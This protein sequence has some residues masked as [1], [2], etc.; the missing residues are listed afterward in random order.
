MKRKKDTY[1]LTDFPMPDSAAIERHLILDVCMNTTTMPDVA[2]LVDRDM[3]TDNRQKIWDVIADL[4]ERGIEPNMF[5]VSSQCLKEFAAEITAQDMIAGGPVE[6][7]SFASKLRTANAKMRTYLAAL[8]ML[9]I[10]QDGSLDEAEVYGAVRDASDEAIGTADGASEKTLSQVLEQ[11]RSDVEETRELAAQGKKAIVTT[12]IGDL[13]YELLG[14]FAPTQL[15]IIAARPSVG[16]TALML[17][18]AKD[19]AAGGA[20]SIIF[21]IEMADTE[22]GQ[23]LMCA[24]GQVDR[25][26]L[27]D[28]SVPDA[29]L[30]EAIKTYDGLPLYI[31]DTACSLNEIVSR[32]TSA[33]NRLGIKAAFIDYL[34]LI[35]PGTNDESVVQ[36]IAVMTRKLKNTAKRLKIPIVLLCQLSRRSAISNKPPQLQDLRDSGSIEQDADVVLMLDRDPKTMMQAGNPDI[37]MYIRKNRRGRRDD[38]ITLHPD[39]SYTKFTSLGIKKPE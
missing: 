22:L 37:L 2:A 3:F 20:P 15:V 16:K 23:R 14:G 10:S 8:R 38:I 27:S 1:G 28:G 35:D 25:R 33:V 26:G 9:E 4:H 30:R 6:T 5:E 12:G 24:T 31:N 19:A 17:Q 11:V 32:I 29:K 7:L 13:D 34:G 18:M 39:D 21:S 36:Q